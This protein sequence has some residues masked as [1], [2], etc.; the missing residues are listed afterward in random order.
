M[1]PMC[2]HHDAAKHGLDHLDAHPCKQNLDSFEKMTFHHSCSRFVVDYTTKDALLC[3][4]VTTV[5]AAIVT[6]LRVHTI[7]NVVKL[8]FQ[9]FDVLK[10][11]PTLDSVLVTWLHDPLKSCL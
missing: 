10:T 8:L 2:V 7:A 1:L 6:E 11:I 3:D 5:A 4:A 9:T